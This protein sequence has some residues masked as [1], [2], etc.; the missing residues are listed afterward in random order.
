MG[1]IMLIISFKFLIFFFMIPGSTFKKLQKAE[2]LQVSTVTKLD[3]DIL[4]GNYNYL[5][6][7]LL[8]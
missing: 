3:F 8:I 6:M 5:I 1:P 7:Y 2:S 4:P